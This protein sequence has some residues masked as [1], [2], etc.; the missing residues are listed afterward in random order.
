MPRDVNGNFSLTPGNPVVSGTPI[1]STVHNATLSDIA[2]AMTDSLSRTGLGGMLAPLPFQDG[3]ASN[4]SI[5]FTLELTSGLYR[6]GAGL[7]S[8]SILG[9]DILGIAADGVYA[10]FPYYEWNTTLAQYV[11]LLNGAEDY[12]IQGEWDFVKPL[13]LAYDGVT[14]TGNTIAGKGALVAHNDPLNNSGLIRVVTV[15][16][17]VADG[18]P[19]DIWLVV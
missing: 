8:F 14:F 6:K 19:G 3:T 15:A 17:G 5:T 12:T 9:D 4:P 7:L 13:I 18:K 1:S 11:P 16:P 2:Q 10:D